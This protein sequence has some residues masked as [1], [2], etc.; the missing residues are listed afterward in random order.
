MQSDE[1]LERMFIKWRDEEWLKI[2]H[3]RIHEV[4][5]TAGNAENQAAIANSRF[6]SLNKAFRGFVSETREAFKRIFGNGTPGFVRQ[7]IDYAVK[8]IE[9]SISIKVKLAV[10]EV[11]DERENNRDERRSSRSWDIVKMALQ[12]I[13]AIIT[14]YIA[15]KFFK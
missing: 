13:Q 4:E 9:D 5:E 3:P 7:E 14:G 11:L 10:T 8:K 6:I 1:F 12:L 15:W 2:Y